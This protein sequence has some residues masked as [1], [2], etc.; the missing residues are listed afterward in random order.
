MPIALQIAQFA[1]AFADKIPALIKA[2]VAVSDVVTA[3]N[4]NK[5]RVLEL[6]TANQAPTQ[7]DWDAMHASLAPLEASIDAAH[8][9]GQ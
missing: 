1:F 8:K 4:A 5:A 2:G 9:D 3:Y 6:A 7:E